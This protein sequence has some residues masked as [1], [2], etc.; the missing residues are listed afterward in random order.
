MKLDSL[1]S[2]FVSE[3]RDLYSAET[4]LL[5]A[6]PKMAAAASSGKLKTAFQDHLQETQGQ[7]DRLKKIFTDLGENP[8]GETCQ[9]MKGL[10]EEA[11]EII[12]SAGDRDVKDAALIGAAQR[13]EHYEIAAYGTARTFAKELKLSDAARLLDETLDEESDADEKLTKI[14]TGGL[15]AKGI[16]DEAQVA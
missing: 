12:E 9:A 8:A 13:V 7:V 10:I 6:L 3:L 15:F 2:L 11:T 14:A 5:E 16:N 4:Q 1:Q